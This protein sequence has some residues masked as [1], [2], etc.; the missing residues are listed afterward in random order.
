MTAC[1]LSAWKLP[2][3]L[4]VPKARMIEDYNKDLRSTS[5]TS[6][7]SKVAEIYAIDNVLKLM[8]LTSLNPWFYPSNQQQNLHLYL[9]C[10]SGYRQVMK[11]S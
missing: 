11:P 6:A 3:V 1:A 10:T 2:D 4:P 9:C 7:L 8:L 5:L